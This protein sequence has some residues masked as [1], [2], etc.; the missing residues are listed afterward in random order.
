ML[1]NLFTIRGENPG[2]S[3]NNGEDLWGG[4]DGVP[5]FGSKTLQGIRNKYFYN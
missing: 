1:E 3:Y 4:E 2:L 5:N